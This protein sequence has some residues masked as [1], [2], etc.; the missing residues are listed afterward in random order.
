[1]RK[2][3]DTPEDAGVRTYPDGRTALGTK[4]REEATKMKTEL[5]HRKDLEADRKQDR[6]LHLKGYAERKDSTGKVS[7]P[8]GRSEY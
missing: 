2:E 4:Q 5:K 6:E 1:M 7:K 3:R 8:G